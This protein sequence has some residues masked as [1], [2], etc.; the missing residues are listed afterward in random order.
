MRNVVGA[1]IPEAVA[2]EALRT[3]E[4]LRS[5]K[6]SPRDAEQAVEVICKMTDEVLN[7]FFVRPIERLGMG[8]T[9]QRMTRWASTTPPR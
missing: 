6:A 1:P 2:L 4:K 3:A 8:G 9:V 7:Y 5:G